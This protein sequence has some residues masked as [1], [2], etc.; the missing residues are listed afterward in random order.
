MSRYAASQLQKSVDYL[1]SAQKRLDELNSASV[2]VKKTTRWKKEHATATDDVANATANVATRTQAWAIQL[3]ALKIKEET[4]NLNKYKDALKEQADAYKSLTDIRKDL[5]KSY[6]KELDYQRQLAQRQKAVVDLQTQLSLARLDTSAAGRARV[7]ELTSQLQD[8]QEALDDFTLEHAIEVLT[9]Q[10]D[11][12]YNEYAKLIQTETDRI[13]DA[14]ANLANTVEVMIK[15]PGPTAE[16][17]VEE[18]KKITRIKPVGGGGAFVAQAYHDGGFAGGLKTNEMF[19]KLMK[20]EFV[21]TPRM[22]NQAITKT[23]PAMISAGNGEGSVIYN[24]PLIQLQCNSITKESMP[25]VEK[26]LNKAVGKIKS[27][28][29]SGLSRAGRKGGVNKLIIT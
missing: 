19:A 5:L 12:Q 15:E 27:A 21:S 25:G 23:I 18:I 13:I 29:G 17:I 1:A 16:K 8:A 2:D 3:R 4:D 11:S 28:V 6:K 20:G 26:L 7:R 24:A 14:I 9:D 10:L 22:M